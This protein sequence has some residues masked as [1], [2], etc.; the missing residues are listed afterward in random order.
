MTDD[1]D[2][3]ARDTAAVVAVMLLVHLTL[4]LLTGA[5]LP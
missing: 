5:G 4:L 2:Q 1:L 3:L